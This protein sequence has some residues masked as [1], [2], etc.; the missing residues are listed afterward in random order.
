MSGLPLVTCPSCQTEAP[1]EVYLGTDDARGVVE[2]MARMPGPP[3]LRKSA[4]RYVALFA[5]AS[6]RLRWGR[7]EKLLGELVEMIES[8]RVERNGRNWPAPVDYWQHGIDAVLANSALRRPLKSHGYLLEV[9]A[10]HANSAEA[11]AERKQEASRAGHTPVGGLP[12]APV[13]A[14]PVEAPRASPETI[15]A[16]LA[17]AKTIVGGAK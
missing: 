4:L 3:S 9:I 6:Q 12:P 1:L 16:T 13:R 14:E 2:I 10:G 8:G 17:A 15:A 5:P 11:Q 7:V